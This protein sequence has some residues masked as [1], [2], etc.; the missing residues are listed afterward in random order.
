MIGMVFGKLCV[1]ARAG[2]NARRALLWLCRCECG[3]TCAVTTNRL[4]AGLTKS[5]GCLKK[6]PKPD[7]SFVGQ[8]FHALT[9]RRYLRSDRNRESIYEYE[10]DCGALGEI[11]RHKIGKTKR[12]PA[13][14]RQAYG[15]IGGTYWC[16]VRGNARAR[17][18]D[19]TITPTEAWELYQ[20]QGGLCALTGLPLTIVPT[21]GDSA[22][23]RKRRPLTGSMANA[24][25]CQ[26]TCS[27]FT[28]SSTSCEGASRCLS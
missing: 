25:M 5:C 23:G 8:H 24:A 9:I 21:C 26:G 4:R 20:A 28:R 1:E 11:R 22:K 12:C 7:L 16:S 14:R 27:G 18:L 2:R 19:F 13:C 6:G 17:G 10:C 3:Q 15:E